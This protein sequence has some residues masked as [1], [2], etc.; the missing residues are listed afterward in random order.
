MAKQKQKKVSYQRR[1]PFEKALSS[2]QNRLERAVAEMT[3]CQTR[4]NILSVEIPKLQRIIGALSPAPKPP[5]R[6][7]AVHVSEVG[8]VD[9]KTPIPTGLEKYLQPIDLT[10]MGSTPAGAEEPP[11]ADDAFLPEA[12]G[13]EVIP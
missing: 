1:D 4:I 13:K 11:Q 3:K 8:K 5:D 10:G 9:L 12:E 2:A 6:P 7:T